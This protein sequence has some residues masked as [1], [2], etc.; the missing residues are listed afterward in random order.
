VQDPTEEEKAL[1]EEEKA[2][3]IKLVRKDFFPNDEAV[4]ECYDTMARET[5]TGPIR[6]RT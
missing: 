4:C 3:V 2:L 6:L 5:G 1:T